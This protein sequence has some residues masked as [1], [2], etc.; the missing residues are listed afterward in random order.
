MA[1]EDGMAFDHGNGLAG[2]NKRDPVPAAAGIGLRHTHYGEFLNGRPATAW[3]E[4]HSEN[5][6]CPGGPRLAT[7]EAIR[8]HYPLSC[9]GVGLSL[10]S[11]EGLDPGHLEQLRSL[12]DRFEPGLVSEHVSWS[13]TGG[14]YLNDLLPLPYTEEALDILVRNIGQ[15]QDAFGR[16]ILIENPSSYVTFAQSTIPEWEFCAEAARRSGCGLL[17]DVNNIHV[18]AHNHGYDALEF[19]NAIPGDLV[20]EIHIAGHADTEWDGRPVLIDDHGSTVK[21]AVWDLLEIALSRFGPKPVLMEWDLDLPPLETLLGEAGRAQA[22]LDRLAPERPALD[23][24][25]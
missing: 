14:D 17:L 21:E 22:L 1:A 2:R 19:L 13:T 20:G 9:H 3:L 18:S 11:A 23:N 10:G 15:A 8:Q 25:A 24:V 12:F 16:R 4:V 6:L 5:Y 7:L